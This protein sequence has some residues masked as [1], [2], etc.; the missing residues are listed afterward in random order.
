MPSRR[1]FLAGSA[2]ATAGLS[3]L[4]P[5]LSPAAA[6]ADSPGPGSAG[7]AGAAGG[8]DRPPNLVVVLADDLGYGELGAYGQRLIRTPRID[9]LAAEGLRFTDS[10]ST[11]AV[12]APSRCSLLTGLHTGHATVRAN[13]S[14]AQGALTAADTTFAQLLRARGYRTGVIGKW[15]F[16]PEA[17]GQASHPNARGFEEFY[18]YIDH[19]HAHQYYPAYLWHNGAK[20]PIPANAGGARAVY[21]PDLIR[22]RALDFLDRH[23]AEPFLLLLT[24]TVP[25]AP[26]DVPDTGEYAGTGWSAANKGH[27]AQVTLFDTL[28]GDVV[29]RLRALGLDGDTVLLVT[30]DNGP[31]EEGGVNP[32]LFDAN[33]PLRGYKRNLYEGGVRVPLIAWGPGRVRPGTSDRPTSL[34]DLLPTLADLAGAPAPSDVDG[35]SVATLLT[36]GAAPARHDHLYWFRDESGVT[37]RANAQDTQRATWLAEGLRKENYKAVRFAPVRDH[38]LPDAQ[39]QV[40]LYDL[41][42]DPGE[43]KDL[44]G[45]QPSKADE[46]VALMRSSWRDGYPRRAFGTTLALPG[47]AVPGRPFAVSATLANGSA[48]PW[49]TAAL[50]LRAPVGWTVTPTSATTAAQLAAGAR[51]TAAWQVTPPAGTAPATAWTLTA[52]GDALAPGGPVRYAADGTV[53]TPPPPPTADAYLSDLPWISAVNGWGP[54]ERDSSNGRNAAGDGTPIAFGGTPYAKGLGTHAYS[55][56]AYHLGGAGDRFTALVGIDDF[57]ARQSTLGATRAKVYGDDRLLLTTPT[58]TAATGPVPV[59]V[60]V[61]GVRVLR[62]VVEDAD[63]R[64]S[65]DHTSW[66][67]ARVTVV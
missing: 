24:P 49:S 62:L 42:V 9:R 29:D 51:L 58:L 10:Y 12:C 53:P 4:P 16:G 63:N 2:A 21:A 18:G 56:L 1:L 25:H 66:A 47:M 61:R 33:G 48:R 39:W 23:A 57:S 60:D 22:Q 59:D 26:S 13:P 50:T 37:S 35:L 52:E 3:G 11:A 43:T 38:T 65:F 54:V 27:A 17:A 15:G 6:T 34:T 41:A 20:E 44:S 5:A 40:E 67:L 8:P 64:T 55:E 7:A 31:H 30:S 36:G 32:D 28:V 19:G 14:G 46:L 45:S